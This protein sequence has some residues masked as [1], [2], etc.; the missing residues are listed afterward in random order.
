MRESFIELECSVGLKLK[1]K[2]YKGGGDKHGN[3]EGVDACSICLL[4][5]KDGERIADL[6]CK[7][8]FH[9]DCI[10]E[11]IKKKVSAIITSLSGLVLTRQ[12]L[13]PQNEQNTCPL[14][15]TKGIA[16]DVLSN[17]IEIGPDSSTIMDADTRN[18]LTIADD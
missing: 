10:A 16:K 6:S 4:D 14:C 18:G 7:H 8:C 2:I 12:Q 1:T 17:E 15:Q 11:W 3:D 5:L 13:T 9:A